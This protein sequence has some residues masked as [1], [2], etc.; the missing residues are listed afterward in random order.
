MDGTRGD[1][2]SART[3][4]S[5][6]CAAWCGLLAGC[7]I[8]YVVVNQAFYPAM[9]VCRP[10]YRSPRTPLGATIAAGFI[11]SYLAGAT[12]LCRRMQVPRGLVV[13]GAVLMVMLAAYVILPTGRC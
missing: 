1:D 6:Q 13:A 9:D 2:L 5:S 3:R 4:R 8:G 10:E 12:F 11:A 7:A